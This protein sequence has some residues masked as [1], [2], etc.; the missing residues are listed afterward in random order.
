ML[1]GELYR[2]GD[3]ELQAD[4]DRC[5]ELLR[6]Y[7]AEA[8]D[9]TR[10]AM[11]PTLLGAAGERVELKPPFRCDYGI[12]IRVGDRVF[13]NYGCVVLDCGPVTIG[14][15][16]QIGP[17]V[18]LLAADHPRDPEVRRSGLELGRPVTIGENVW[19]GAG[20]IVC[21]GVT[22]GDGSVIGAGSVVTR[23]VP[24]GVVAAGNPCRVLHPAADGS[25][26]RR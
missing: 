6:R 5:Q 26:P 18:Q 15:D 10:R 25:R 7:N 16:T 21:P 13:L 19:I 17:G 1:A 8:D 23:D 20:A 9:A 3:P 2:A 14:S 22:I 24:A 12:H 11:I 4:M